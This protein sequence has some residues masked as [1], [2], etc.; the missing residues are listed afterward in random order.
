MEQ[1]EDVLASVIGCR[2]ESGGSED[3]F[4]DFHS[5]VDQV[6]SLTLKEEQKFSQNKIGNWQPVGTSTGSEIYSKKVRACKTF[7]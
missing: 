7:Y 4:K 5:H 3:Y 6:V 1:P 2:P